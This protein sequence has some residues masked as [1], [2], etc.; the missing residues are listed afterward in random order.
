MESVKQTLVSLTPE[1][2]ICVNDVTSI[3]VRG[4]IYTG[5]SEHTNIEFKGLSEVL[6]KIDDLCNL[7]RCPMGW[8]HLA[9]KDPNSNFDE[10]KAAAILSKMRK[11]DLDSHRG[12]VATF[13][14][15]I[16]SRRSATW[17]GEVRHMETGEICKFESELQLMRFMEKAWD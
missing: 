10:K 15:N 17:Q 3:G 9:G 7:I 11:L 14:L 8:E 13:V 2:L 16:R 5:D 12:K 1:Y 6:I 4:T